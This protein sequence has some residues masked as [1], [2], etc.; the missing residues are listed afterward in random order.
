MVGGIMLLLVLVIYLKMID[1]RAASR[2]RKSQVQHWLE[3]VEVF[4]SVADD[5]NALKTIEQ[6]KLA[7]PEETALIE[8]E[9]TIRSRQSNIKSNQNQKS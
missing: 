9:N 1:A 5:D 2:R 3:K 8:K 7:L 6:A 4:E